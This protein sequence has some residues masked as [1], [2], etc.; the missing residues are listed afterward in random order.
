[1]PSGEAK[2]SVGASS[3]DLFPNNTQAS[4]IGCN[5]IEETALFALKICCRGDSE[6]GAKRVTARFD[7]DLPDPDP[8]EPE[9]LTQHPSTCSLRATPAEPSVSGRHAVL[10]ARLQRV[11]PAIS[12]AITL[13]PTVG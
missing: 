8:R 9:L 13:N 1:M 7:E 10:A 3:G 12:V 11:D 2:D 5:A 6:V 4:A